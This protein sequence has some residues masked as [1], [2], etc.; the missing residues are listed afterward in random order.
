MSDMQR[1]R[2]D[3]PPAFVIVTFFTK[4]PFVICLKEVCFYFPYAK[5]T[6]TSLLKTVKLSFRILYI[7]LSWQK[8]T[9]FTLPECLLVKM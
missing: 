5:C 8:N 4:L 1:C 3:K 2:I 9:F 6:A 7:F